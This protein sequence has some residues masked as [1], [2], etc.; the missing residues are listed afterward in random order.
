MVAHTFIINNCFLKIRSQSYVTH[1]SLGEVHGIRFFW[2]VKCQH[3]GSQWLKEKKKRQIY[4]DFDFTSSR[5]KIR[6]L[7]SLNATF[8]I[9]KI[10]LVIF[11]D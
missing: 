11:S 5:Y 7:I 10:S 9:C 3:P 8:V 1:C 2:S 6:D 4:V